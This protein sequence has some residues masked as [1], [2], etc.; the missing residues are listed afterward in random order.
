MTDELTDAQNIDLAE[1]V[2]IRMDCGQDEEQATEKALAELE[3][4]WQDIAT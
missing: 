4:W 1:R 2:S 3:I